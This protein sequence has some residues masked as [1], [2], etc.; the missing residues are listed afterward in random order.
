[1][2]KVSVRDIMSYVTVRSVKR[3][4]ERKL[5]PPTPTYI[6]YYADFDDQGGRESKLIFSVLTLELV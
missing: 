2:A 3:S 5:F 4:L 1:M 6:D